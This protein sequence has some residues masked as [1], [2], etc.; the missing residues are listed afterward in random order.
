MIAASS[1]AD[2]YAQ[3]QAYN[4]LYA[5]IVGPFFL[6]ILLMFLSGLPCPNALVLKND[7]RKVTTGTLTQDI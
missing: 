6:T 5:T 2:G 3:G 4:A 1:A 7:M